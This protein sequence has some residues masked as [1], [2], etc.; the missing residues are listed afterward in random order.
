MAS[1]QDKENF[2]TFQ[3]SRNDSSGSFTNSFEVLQMVKENSTTGELRSQQNDRRKG[4]RPPKSHYQKEN[5]AKK[6]YNNYVSYKKLLIEKMTPQEFSLR[7]KKLLV[8]SRAST[9]GRL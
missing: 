4:V 5:F 9:F 1:P 7:K 8:E 3:D 6:I 2:V